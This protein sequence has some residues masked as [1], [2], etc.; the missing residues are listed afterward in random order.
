MHNMHC[1]S[2]VVLSPHKSLSTQVYVAIFL[3]FIFL[4]KKPFIVSSIDSLLH[5]IDWTIKI[6]AQGGGRL[7]SR[8]I[9]HNHGKFDFKADFPHVPN[10]SE[11][12]LS[13]LL[14]F[15]WRIFD[16]LLK[17]TTLRDCRRTVLIAEV[18]SEIP[19]N[20][21]CPIP[22]LPSLPRRAKGR[23]LNV[24]PLKHQQTLHQ[25]NRGGC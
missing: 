12:F 19:T 4:N 5:Q 6:L 15:G 7:I 17:G 9:S 21:Q 24:S 8:T 20:S 11:H 2:L 23:V 13:K 1:I 3:F 22:T 18:H 25:K 10:S 14:R 16:S